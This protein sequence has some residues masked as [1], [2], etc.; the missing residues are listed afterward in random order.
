MT[1]FLIGK[2][3]KI[4]LCNIQCIFFFLP[5]CS[6]QMLYIIFCMLPAFLFCICF[7]L[8][9]FRWIILCCYVTV[10]LVQR[11]Q[12]YPYRTPTNHMLLHPSKTARYRVFPA[13]AMH[14]LMTHGLRLIVACKSLFHHH[15]DQNSSEAHTQHI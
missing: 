3:L 14:W 1:L 2:A 15:H 10:L 5:L 13:P 12:G 8:V 4:I 9:Y 11:F 6:L 7:L